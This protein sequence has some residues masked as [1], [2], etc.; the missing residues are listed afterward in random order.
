MKIEHRIKSTY[1][2]IF[3]IVIILTTLVVSAIV[4]IIMSQQANKLVHT[5]SLSK[6][7]LLL[8]YL[9]GNKEIVLALGGANVF[10]DLLN[11][12][13]SSA[14]FVALKMKV[15]DYLA[16]IIKLDSN[17]NELFLV[18]KNATIISSTNKLRTNSNIASDPFYREG[19]KRLFIKEVYSSPVTKD[20]A[21]GI[22]TPIN[23]TKTGKFLGVLAVRFD[24]K[25]LFD[26][27]NLQLNLGRTAEN[28]LI[29][30]K[31]NLLTS[32]LYLNKS[33][34]LKKQ[35]I[36]QNTT[37][38]LKDTSHKDDASHIN[39][40]SDYRGIPILGAHSYIKEVDWCL[41]TKIDLIE[42]YYP[43]LGIILFYITSIGFGSLIFI[44]VGSSLA[45]TI[46]NPLEKLYKGIQVIQKGEEDYKINLHPSD[47]IEAITQQFNQ[48]MISVNDAK[49]SV[50]SKVIEQTAEISKKSKGLLDQKKAILNILE[51][52]E[53]QKKESD[54]LALDLKKFKLA[55]ENATDHIIITDP[56]GIV[57]FANKS[58]ERITGFTLS[59]VMGKKAGNKELWGGLMPLEFYKNLWKVVKTDKK[60][61]TGEITNKRKNGKTYISKASIS[62]IFNKSGDVE[63]FVGIERDVTKEF[64]IDKMKTE[65][66]SLASH[67]LRTPLS[68]IRWFTEMLLNGDAGKLTNEQTE[69]MNN[70]DQSNNR[71]IELVNSLLNVSR[72][73]SGRIIVE[74]TPTDIKK[75]VEEIKKE[76]EVKLQEKNQEL[77]ININTDLPLISLD[78]KLIFQVYLNL[79][80]NA[81]KYSPPNGKIVLSI[82]KENDT[83]ITQVSDEGYGIPKSEE[84][85]I[86]SKFYR[87]TNALKNE[88]EGN[89]LGLYLVKSIIESSGGK[90]WFV[91]IEGKGTSFYFSI[92][93][94]GMKAK[95]GEVHIS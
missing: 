90:V 1:I 50:E 82:S 37:S 77:M 34:V 12:S 5:A 42:I 55:V 27:V 40:Y 57:L 54:K 83:I 6:T 31:Y 58:V 25:P 70:I 11:E 13:S 35:I 3:L 62:P 14:G 87:A 72:I 71:M 16:N 68:A 41:I 32:S 2:R 4:G 30:N 56:D 74:P 79:L 20:L 93:L 91:S 44:K 49:A 92:P 29:N 78:Q 38:C 33:L 10:S 84:S 43:F 24:T 80:T 48:L 65:F 39:L 75:L 45:Q 89:G 7:E 66:I 15:E 17:I 28:F 67:Q 8:T 9:R 76:V 47:E 53:L 60:P 64:E 19:K 94:A 52:V 46:T 85:H 51:D 18:D 59:E 86:F 95:E 69:F 81:I 21:W 23:D 63:Y 26:M 36:T 73:D 88:T 22:S 61:F